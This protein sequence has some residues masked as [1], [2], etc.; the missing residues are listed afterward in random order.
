MWRF[1]P[2]QHGRL[3]F[4]PEHESGAGTAECTPAFPLQSPAKRR[5]PNVT[6]SAQ[7]AVPMPVHQ[8][9]AS[10]LGVREGQVS[11]AIGLLDGGATGPFVARYRKE[12]TGGRRAT[13]LRR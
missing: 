6:P 10:E 1:A 13:H 9:I 5:I 7:A 3:A 8:R 4:Q 11:A 12:A 2:A